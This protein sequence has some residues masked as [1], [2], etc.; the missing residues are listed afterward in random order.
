MVA[1]K[2]PLPAGPRAVASGPSPP[3]RIFRTFPEVVD[4]TLWLFYLGP[5]NMTVRRGEPH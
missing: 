4:F 2:S 3:G 5:V 1:P